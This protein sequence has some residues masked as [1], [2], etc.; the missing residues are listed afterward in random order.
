[1]ETHHSRT[2]GTG[3]ANN[4][5][6]DACPPQTTGSTPGNLDNLTSRSNCSSANIF[7]NNGGPSQQNTNKRQPQQLKW[8]L[9][10]NDSNGAQCL[11]QQQ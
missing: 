9:A 1:M 3:Q 5:S 10:S 8:I 4:N 7:Q 2:E 11:N 6:G